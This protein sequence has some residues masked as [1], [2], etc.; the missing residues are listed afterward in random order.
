MA[1]AR[2]SMAPMDTTD[3]A[4]LNEEDFADLLRTTS[5][6]LYRQRQEL[7]KAVNDIAR[8]LA[9]ENNKR[10]CIEDLRKEWTTI[11]DVGGAVFLLF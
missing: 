10:G 4:L 7:E 5:A 8:R 2:Y 1:T 9:S 3:S 11:A 6:N